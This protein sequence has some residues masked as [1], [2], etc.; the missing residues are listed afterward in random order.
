MYSLSLHQSRQLERQRLTSARREDSKHRFPIYRRS[1]SILLQWL[2]CISAKP[3]VTEKSFEILMHIQHTIAV[4]T[5]A[6]T[7]CMAHKTNYILYIRII[8][9]YPSRGDRPVVAGIYQC[10]SI[11]KF[12]RALLYESSQSSVFT[13]FPLV[14]YLNK[15]YK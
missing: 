9:K 8:F 2:P 3:V 15:I 4:S 12:N 10:Q 5:T 14:A 11:C 7:S 6:I 1:C 13:N